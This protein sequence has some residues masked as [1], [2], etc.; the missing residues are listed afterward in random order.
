M[1]TSILGEKID[2]PFCIAP[3]GM[4]KFA[5][6]EGELATARGWYL[7]NIGILHAHFSA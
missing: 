2:V 3:T 6:P 1:S 4:H 7:L 5:N